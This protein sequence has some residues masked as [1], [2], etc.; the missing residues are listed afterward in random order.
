MYKCTLPCEKQKQK[1]KCIIDTHLK[2]VFKNL[3]PQIKG[4]NNK[5][6]IWHDSTLAPLT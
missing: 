4:N 3:K 1:I 6:R 5:E 2:M